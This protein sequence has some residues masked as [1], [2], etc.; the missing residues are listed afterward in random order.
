MSTQLN[1]SSVYVYPVDF[2]IQYN[3]NTEYRN[4]LR[5]VFKMNPSKYPPINSTYMDDESRDELEYDE[6]AAGIAMNT[7]FEKTKNI[8]LFQFLY[9]KAAARMLSADKTIGLSVLCCYDNFDGFHNCLVEYFNNP[10]QF[11]KTNLKYQEIL[12]RL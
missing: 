1:K 11:D 3:N 5:K 10:T 9:E 8:F 4:C 2:Q 6:E 7:V 12:N